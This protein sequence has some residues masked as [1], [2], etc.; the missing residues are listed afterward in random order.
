MTKICYKV[1]A[2]FET[3]KSPLIGILWIY[4][5]LVLAMAEKQN[6]RKG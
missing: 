3:V 5:S 4:E 1:T 6:R 2:A